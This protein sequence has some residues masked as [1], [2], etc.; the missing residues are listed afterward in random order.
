MLAACEVLAG[1]NPDDPAILTWLTQALEENDP[2]I[3]VTAVRAIGKSGDGALQVI[4][5]LI[6]ALNDKYF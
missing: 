2:Q 6:D 1:G 3:R 5:K 4:D